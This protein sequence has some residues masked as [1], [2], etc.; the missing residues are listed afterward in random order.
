MVTSHKPDAVTNSV[1]VNSAL[2]KR[3]DQLVIPS[4]DLVDFDGDDLLIMCIKSKKMLQIIA[5]KDLIDRDIVNLTMFSTTGD[6]LKFSVVMSQ[7]I[8]KDEGFDLLWTSGVCTPDEEAMKRFGIPEKMKDGCVWEGLISVPSSATPDKIKADI[9]QLV[10]NH[11]EHGKLSKIDVK[12][13]KRLNY[14]N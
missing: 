12:S 5:V 10:K 9:N 13:V 6:L 4:K 7:T 8:F 3:E 11:P 2:V 1:L 14:G